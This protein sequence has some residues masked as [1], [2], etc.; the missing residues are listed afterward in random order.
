MNPIAY[1]KHPISSTITCDCLNPTEVGSDCWAHPKHHWNTSM[2]LVYTHL[3]PSQS[4]PPNYSKDP[5]GK[6]GLGMF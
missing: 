1:V 3:I 4:L 6:T 5:S 2:Q